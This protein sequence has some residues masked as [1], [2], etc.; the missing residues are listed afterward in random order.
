MFELN[1]ILYLGVALVIGFLLGKATHWLKLTAIIGYIVAGIILGPVLGLITEDMLGSNAV[2]ITVDI[3]LGLVGFIIGIGFTKRFL[4]KYGKMSMIIAVIQSVATLLSIF[5]GVYLFT[6]LFTQD[7]YLSLILGAIGLAT[8]PAGTLAAIYMSKGRGK[9]TRMTIAVVGLD[10]GIAIILFVLVLTAVKVSTGESLKLIDLVWIPVREI[11][12]AI[13]IGI[14]FGSALAYLAKYLYHREDVF[15]LTISFIF[16]SIG[17][18]E[19]VGASFILAC[20]VLGLMFINISPRM[21]K[22]TRANIETILAPIFVLFF[23]IAGLEIQREVFAEAALITFGIIIIYI[24][25]RTLGKILG[26][27][28]AG[29]IADAPES[30]KKYIGF[31]LLSQAGVAIGLAIL[32]SNEVGDVLSLEDI[33]LGT[34]TITIITITTIFFEIVGPLGVKYAL[35]NAGEAND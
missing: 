28:F 22:T 26:G 6:Y 13:A 21:G 10:D 31:A 25:F 2:T 17:L 11:F 34:L 9:L 14:L 1:L 7:I 35:T 5:I 19:A 4:K 8:A 16:I 20:M 30:I 29:K 12:G 27:N 3:T 15:I 24:V 18:C 32:V 23:A 33:P